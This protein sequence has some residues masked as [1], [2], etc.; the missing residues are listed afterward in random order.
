MATIPINGYELSYT[1]NGVSSDAEAINLILIH[2][3]G[4]QE[5]DWPMAWRSVDDL[6]RSLGL[7]PKDHSGDLDKYPI[8]SLD[9]PGHGKSGG[10]SKA[11]VDDYASAINDFVI[12][13]GLNNVC[14]VGHS[15]GAAIALTAA[16][17][18]YSWLAGIAMIGGAS[19]LNVNDAILDGL[20]N[21]FEQTID[22]IIKYSWYKDTGSF[23]KQK[24]KQRMLE[25]GSK[26]VHDDFYACSRFDL[27]DKLAEI[28]TPAL[29]IASDYDRMVPLNVSQEMAGQLTG[30]IFIGL[31]NCGHFQHIEQTG[32]VATE[33]SS[34]LLHLREL[35][36]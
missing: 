29:V 17:E 2:G 30:S 21:S 32:K 22:N 19:K 31:E 33:I 20:Q 34:F 4:G 18:R 28:D 25:A 35:G 5:I 15:M 9:L 10:E 7:T 24:A 23:F 27:T 12:A 1:F 11:S 16:L 13:L 8:Y 3:A 14:L 6:T 26:V 36:S